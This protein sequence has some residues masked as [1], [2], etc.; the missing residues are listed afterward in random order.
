MVVCFLW[1]S[2]RAHKILTCE[3][4]GS[5]SSILDMLSL[6]WLSN[7][8][9]DMSS[10]PVDIWVWYSGERPGLDVYFGELVLWSFGRR[11]D[12][13]WE[14]EKRWGSVLCPRAPQF[15]HW[16][17]EKTAVVTEKEQNP[18]EGPVTLVQQILG[19]REKEVVDCWMLLRSWESWG[20]VAS[21]L[22][23]LVE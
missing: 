2:L 1:Q 9:V 14:R 5:L 8:Q 3:K 13:K 11:W 6:K 23:V 10:T 18:G 7:I 20:S 21:I 22:T 17:E 4:T 15:R 19:F 12:I 16:A